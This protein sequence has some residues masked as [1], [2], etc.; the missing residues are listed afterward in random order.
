MKDLMFLLPL[1]GVMIIYYLFIDH[2]DKCIGT[3]EALFTE[4]EC[5]SK[6][7]LLYKNIEDLVSTFKANHLDF[8]V[9]DSPSFPRLC[10]Y[11]TVLG[12]SEND[13]DNLLICK[14]AKHF[15]ADVLTV[16]KCNLQVYHEIFDCE[17]VDVVISD[18]SEI[19]SILNGWGIIC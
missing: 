16:A 15:D 7:V 19:K 5:P 11:K 8:D 4:E 1:L 18:T 14:I 2:I 13:L 12:V 9:I 6:D 3:E 10:F 17:E